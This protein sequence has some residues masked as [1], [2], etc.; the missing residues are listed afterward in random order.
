[1]NVAALDLQ[2][3]LVDGDKALELFG[4]SARFKN[5]CHCHIALRNMNAF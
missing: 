4:E 5:K 1:M 3:D 2:I